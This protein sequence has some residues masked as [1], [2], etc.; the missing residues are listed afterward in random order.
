MKK[1]KYIIIIIIAVSIII[2]GVLGFLLLHVVSNNKPASNQNV[3]NTPQV[4]QEEN[5]VQNEEANNQNEENNSTVNSLVGNQIIIDP[6]ITTNPTPD[7]QG[8]VMESFATTYYYS[9]LNSN[10]KS[11]YD[12]LKQNK[13]NLIS[14]NLVIDYGTS[15]N[16]LL[17]SDGGEDKLKED[18]QAAWDAFIYDN[19]DL[20]YIDTEKVSLNIEYESVGGI[21]TYKVSIGPGNNS[22]YYKSTFKTK[23]QVESAKSAMED[24]R[25]QMTEQIST[26]GMYR[27]IGKVH[28]WII[29]TVAYENSQSSN[30]Q[31]TIYGALIN[32]KAS[33]EGYARTFKYFM[34]G[35]GVPCILIA[36]KG[37]NSQ[38][39]E[40]SHAWNYVQI[41]EKWYAVDVT[42]DDPILSNG[43]QLSS[44]LKYKYFLKGSDEF[45]K[46]HQVDGRIS[47]NGI[48][49][50][51]PTLSTQNYKQ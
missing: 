6:N 34:D 40:E 32:N 50:R 9:Q 1:N 38:G 24:I 16:T 41:N 48:S 45:L 47:E 51:F 23:E 36:G 29:E 7:N 44:D 42:W 4:N 19:M 18:F 43:A 27:K 25:R 8:S 39:Q 26:D 33:C 13:A 11:I 12:K 21:R 3:Q 31:Y 49:F 30:D 28:N 15:F 2:V 22:N 14:G 46:D 5:D 35:A 37:T 10:A 17:N 20:F